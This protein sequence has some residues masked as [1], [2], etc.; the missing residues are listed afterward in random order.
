MKCL[1]KQPGET[2]AVSESYSRK[3]KQSLRNK[4]ANIVKVVNQKRLLVEKSQ[5]VKLGSE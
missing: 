2:E 5:E 4:R 1:W 3:G